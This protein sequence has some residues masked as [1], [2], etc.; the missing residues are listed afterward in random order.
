M[1]S[2]KTEISRW[3]K[4]RIIFVTLL[5]LSGFVAVGVRAYQLQIK[6]G[7]RLRE[8]AEQQ[9]LKEIELPS[10]RGM[11]YDRNVAPL[12]VSVDVDSVYV[13]PRMIGKQAKVVAK[14][15]SP[16]L[17]MN[18]KQLV[19]KFQSKLYFRWVKRRINP[20]I[21]KAVSEL[22][23]KGVF[24]TKESRRFYPNREL[25]GTVLGFAG[26]DGK[27]LEGLELKYDGWL[28]GSR[29]RF[30]GL[31]DAL[32]RQ[33]LSKGFD[34]AHTVGHDLLLSLD[35]FIQYE[36]EQAIAT[37]TVRPNTG[38]VAAVVMDPHKGDILAI[39]NTPSFDPNLFHEAKPIQWRNRTVTDAFEPG[40]IMKPFSVAA[41]LETGAIRSQDIIDCGKGQWK[42][43]KHTIHDTHD[44]GKLSVKGVLQKSSN[45]GVSKIA[46]SLGKER[47]YK[48]LRRF[49]FGRATGVGLSGERAGVLRRPNQWS[50]IGL[51][52]ISFG[53]GM[54]ATVMQ[55]ARALAVMA[56]GGILIEPRLVLEVRKPNGD[57]VESFPPRGVRVLNE[58]VADEIREMLASVTEE[59]GT[60]TNAALKRFKVAGK[61][62]TAQK[63]DPSTG[64]YSK[65][66]WVSS[67]IG[68]VPVEKPRLVIA[69]VVNEPSGKKHYGGEVAAP[70]F[71]QIAEKALGY[72]GVKPDKAISEYNGGEKSAQQA[73]KTPAA[74]PNNQNPRVNVEATLS[75]LKDLEEVTSGKTG[76]G[77]EI[78]SSESP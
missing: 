49:G 28:R 45:I 52:N 63:V 5:I 47:L 62:G 23:I 6:E 2:K 35:K 53:Q 10:R 57:A 42:V 17:N 24:L 38:W 11:I 55:F 30:P 65:E 78:I 4:I 41:A 43:G 13:N 21:A 37:A 39:A 76:A 33:V 50:T 16:V 48:M 31:Q 26:A 51:A 68:I 58:K 27:G 54:T 18:T 36:T 60:G 71:K 46:F 14:K 20:K 72:L 67:F 19:E 66:L 22:K 56:N 40:S 75:E 34:A 3:I 64:A 59:E 15:L 69:V 12:A 25:A 73:A 29:V 8:M 44:N 74:L 77:N 70:I 61:T 9:Y 32:G 1:I 7:A